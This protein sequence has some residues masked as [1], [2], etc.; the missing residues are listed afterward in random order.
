MSPTRRS[1]SCQKNTREMSKILSKTKTAIARR[2]KR[3]IQAAKIARETQSL[4]RARAIAARTRKGWPK[5]RKR[6]RS[7]NPLFKLFL[8]PAMKHAAAGE[9]GLALPGRGGIPNGHKAHHE[10]AQ[11]SRR[12]AGKPGSMAHARARL[13]RPPRTLSRETSSAGRPNGKRLAEH[14]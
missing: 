6:R 5:R 8:C 4:Q 12:G 1:M 14:A 2:P 10:R 11:A 9:Y 3:K 7:G 13:P